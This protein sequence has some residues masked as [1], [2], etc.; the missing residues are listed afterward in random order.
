MGSPANQPKGT[1]S[2][3]SKSGSHT[4]TAAEAE[5]MNVIWAHEPVSMPDIVEHLPRPL[6]Y[7]TVMTTVRILEE[8]AFV[9]QCGKQGRA[10]VYQ[11]LV[12]KEQVRGS[13][14]RELAERLFG[15]SVKSLVMNLIQDR[16]LKKDELAELKKM[17]QQMEK[18]A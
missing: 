15:G 18:Q 3:K 5:V 13:M 2:L 8:K 7:S 4:L 12:G 16:E 6:A 11:S 10:F 14:A 17:L 1:R 9:T